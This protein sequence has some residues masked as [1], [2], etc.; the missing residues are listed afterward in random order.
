MAHLGHRVMGPAIRAEPVGAREEI[1]LEDRLQ[2]QLQGCLDHPVPYRGDPQTAPLATGLGDHPLT[3]RQ[4]AEATVA[5]LRPQLVE[6]LLDAPHHLHVGHGLTV[7]SGGASTLVAPHPIPGDQQERR[8]GDEVVQIIEPAMRII[9]GPTVQ[10]GLDLPYPTLRPK[11]RKLRFIGVHQR[12]PGIPASF[13]PTCWPPSPCARL[14]RARTT[15]GP[16]PRPTAIGRQRTCPPPDRLPGG[17]G[18]R[19]RFPRSPGIDR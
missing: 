10:F 3:H 4:R 8:I 9:T 11:Q 1:R 15:T 12:P 19:G 2:H 16:P 13:L 5:Q 7:H 6:E 14:S 17:E 18:D